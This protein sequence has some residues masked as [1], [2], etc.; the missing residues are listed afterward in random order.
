MGCANS[1][2]E[3]AALDA[4]SVQGVGQTERMKSRA[5]RLKEKKANDNAGTSS[6]LEPP[7]LDDSGKLTAEEV[8]KRSTSS[9]TSKILELGTDSHKITVEVCTVW[10]I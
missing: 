10:K 9:I 8:V 3:K 5:Q 2:E 6:G 1:K 7:K 4:R